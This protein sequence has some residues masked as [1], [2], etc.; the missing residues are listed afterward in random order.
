MPPARALLQWR[1]FAVLLLCV[2]LGSVHCIKEQ[3]WGDIFASEAEALE[4]AQTAQAGR[5][6]LQNPDRP[7]LNSYGG[8]NMTSKPRTRF[9]SGCP[10]VVQLG[11]A[12]GPCGVQLEQEELTLGWSRAAVMSIKQQLCYEHLN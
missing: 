5:S 4:G 10:C 6:L 12:V 7:A 8:V 2:S 1:A 9:L 3:V 11:L